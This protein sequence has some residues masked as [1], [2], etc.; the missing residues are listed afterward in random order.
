MVLL[1][2]IAGIFVHLKTLKTIEMTIKKND[3]KK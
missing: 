2:V 1:V 3:Y